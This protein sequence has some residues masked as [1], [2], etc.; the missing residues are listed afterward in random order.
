[1]NKSWNLYL[2]GSHWTEK[3]DRGNAQFIEN[4]SIKPGF[5]GLVDS[6]TRFLSLKRVQK[7]VRVDSETFALKS[8]IISKRSY[9]YKRIPVV[10][11]I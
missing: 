3:N 11:K 7:N 6:L 10:P 2:W 8:S 9:F 5:S 4:R 1:M